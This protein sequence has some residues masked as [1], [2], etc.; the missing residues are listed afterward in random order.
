M[1]NLPT[2][3]SKKL[4]KGGGMWEGDREIVKICLRVKWMV[5]IISLPV[6]YL[7]PAELGKFLQ[8]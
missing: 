4:L 1:P 2:E 3:S 8:S 5:P 6:K 7:L